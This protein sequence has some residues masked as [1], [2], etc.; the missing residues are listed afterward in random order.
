MTCTTSCYYSFKI[1]LL[2][3]NVRATHHNQLLST[4]FKLKE[5][6]DTSTGDVNR[7]AKSP[8]DCTVNREDLGMRLSCFGTIKMQTAG[9]FHLFQ[10]GNRRTIG[11]EHSKN[12]KEKT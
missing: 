6:C 8:N 4:K 12:N 1:F 7:A 3:K 9:T 2:Y 10:G 11:L 5:L